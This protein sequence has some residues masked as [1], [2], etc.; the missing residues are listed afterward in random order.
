MKINGTSYNMIT[1]VLKIAE[2]DKPLVDNILRN[3]ISRE[4]AECFRRHVRTKAMFNDLIHTITPHD[5]QER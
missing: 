4:E 3:S 5:T 2:E 1:D